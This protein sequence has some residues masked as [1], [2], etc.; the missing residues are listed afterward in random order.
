MQTFYLQHGHG[1]RGPFRTESVQAREDWKPQHKRGSVVACRFQVLFNGR[2]HRL[3]SDHAPS[4]RGMPHF[5]KSR[6]ERI[7]VSGVCP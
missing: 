7:A 4:A 1:T 2:W 3:Y 6:G 5:I